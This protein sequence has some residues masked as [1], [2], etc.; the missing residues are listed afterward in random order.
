VF[1]LSVA[2]FRASSCDFVDR[3]FW[4][5]EEDDPRNHTN[6]HE[7]NTNGIRVFTHTLKPGENEMKHSGPRMNP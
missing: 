4:W 5:S 3:S 6:S 1:D 2:A 7:Q